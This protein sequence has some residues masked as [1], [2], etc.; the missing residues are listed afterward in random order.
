MRAGRQAQR[1]YQQEGQQTQDA[2]VED[3]AREPASAAC[4]P[5]NVIE[6]NLDPAEH[7][8]GRKNQQYA[9]GHAQSA[10]AGVLDEFVDVVSD[11]FAGFD[12]IF[13]FCEGRQGAFP[14]C[15]CILDSG[16]RG[17]GVHI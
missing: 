8:N 16:F 12:G 3:D 17:P 6:G 9:A 15:A 1:H 13:G 5:P 11:C 4:H 14:G 7:G 2:P 10:A